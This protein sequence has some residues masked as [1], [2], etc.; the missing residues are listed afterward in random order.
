MFYPNA[1]INFNQNGEYTKH[2]YNGTE[3]IASR[4]GDA[5]MNI[6]ANNND[7]LGF[8]IMQ[9]DEQAHADLLELVEAGDVPIETLSVDVTSLQPTGSPSDIFCLR[10]FLLWETCARRQPF[11]RRAGR[12]CSVWTSSRPS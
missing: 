10:C 7:R 8:R 4:L 9:A 5:I 6:S 3:R 12:R 1:Y 2:Y 11:S